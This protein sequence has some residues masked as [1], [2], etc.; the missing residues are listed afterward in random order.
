MTLGTPCATSAWSEL[1][2]AALTLALVDGAVLFPAVSV[3]YSNRAVCY[4]KQYVVCVCVTCA[5]PERCRVGVCS[6]L[7]ASQSLVLNVTE[8]F[9]RLWRRTARRRSSWTRSTRGWVLRSSFSSSSVVTLS[10]PPSPRR[11]AHHYL[12]VNYM[13]KGQFKSA[14]ASL[15]L[16]VE[17]AERQHRPPAYINDIKLALEK[18]VSAVVPRRRRRRHSASRCHDAGSRVRC[19]CHRCL[20][21]QYAEEERRELA[22]TTELREYFCAPSPVADFDA[23]KH[24]AM[25]ERLQDALQYRVRIARG[26]RAAVSALL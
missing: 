15:E 10:L 21:L 4:D 19:A 26:E 22:S 25:V 5:R 11:Q 18:C 6:G 14:Q 23:D 3:L 7:R 2:C 9:T 13:R 12:G 24:R 17:R 20:R 8:A 1:C 16:A